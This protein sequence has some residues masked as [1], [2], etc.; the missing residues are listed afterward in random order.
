MAASRNKG[1]QPGNLRGEGERT[2]RVRVHTR[3]TQNRLQLPPGQPIRR[4]LQ[5]QT[6][7]FSPVNANSQRT[8]QVASRKLPQRQK[9]EHPLTSFLRRLPQVL[10][11]QTQP[12]QPQLKSVSPRIRNPANSQHLPESLPRRGISP[13]PPQVAPK[14]PVRPVISLQSERLKP[15]TRGSN[16]QFKPQ[17]QRNPRTR[18]NANTRF[19]VTAQKRA[20]QRPQPISTPRQ[21]KRQYRRQS[22]RSFQILGYVVRLLILGIGISAFVG[23]LLSVLDPTT[24]GLVNATNKTEETQ[25]Q[26]SPTST[27][28]QGELPLTQELLPLKV[29]LQTLIGQNSEL[30]PGVFVVDLDTGAYLDWDGGLIFAAASTIKVPILVAFFQAVDAGEIRLDEVLTM[31]PEMVAGGSGNMQYKPA[32]SQFTA[33]DVATKMITISDNTATNMLITRLG[34]VNLLNQKFSSW[35]LTTTVIRNPLPDLAGTNT[36]SPK[37][38]AHLM[39]MVNQGQLLSMRSRDWLLGIMRQTENSSLLPKGLGQGAM[40]AHKTGNIGSVLADAGLVDMPTG[41]RY[42]V[43]IMVRRPHDDASAQNLIREISRITY[44]YFDKQQP[45]PGTNSLPKP[46][47]AT[48]NENESMAPGGN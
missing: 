5:P 16:S 43:S 38:L 10:F 32:G 14:R 46:S 8:R 33:L 15:E 23:T 13:T 40:I 45:Y 34:G 26:V 41:K 19:G 35:G 7:S 48:L 28:N 42:I 36:T 17:P 6:R 4:G 27:S 1:R 20:R 30:Q 22:N 31:Q 39:S 21:R 3:S 44:D 25:V 11:A 47:T 18:P 9:R 2:V 37:E 12:T 29:Q 24:Q